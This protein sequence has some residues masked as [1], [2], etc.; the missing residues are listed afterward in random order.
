MRTAKCYPAYP[1]S[2]EPE[3]ARPGFHTSALACAGGQLH[4]P[5][6][7]GQCVLLTATGFL[8]G[9]R[10]IVREYRQP[11][12]RQDRV[13]DDRGSL[14]I[15]FLVPPTANA[16]ADALTFVGIE[17]FHPKSGSGSVAVTV[18]HAAAYRFVRFR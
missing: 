9:Q 14:A 13:A 10:I 2:R 18:P 17:L 12:W 8:P 11:G 16:T 3:S 1:P 6:H 4:G 5:L 7:S 15:R